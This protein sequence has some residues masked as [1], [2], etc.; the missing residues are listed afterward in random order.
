M[1]D[2]GAAVG[3]EVTARERADAFHVKLIRW[4]ER[5]V[6]LDHV[7]CRAVS[8]TPAYKCIQFYQV[9]LEANG[10]AFLS[11]LALTANEFGASK[12]MVMD[13]S[14]FI[15]FSDDSCESGNYDVISN[16]SRQ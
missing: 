14:I 6:G 1:A 7:M 11:R 15:E 12:L 4:M 3:V 16:S 10:F 2:S 9:D 5:N 8:M 13:S